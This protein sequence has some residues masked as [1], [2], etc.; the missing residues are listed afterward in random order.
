MANIALFGLDIGKQTFHVV[1]HDAQGRPVFKRQFTRSR[2]LEFFATQPAARIVMEAC[3]GA[4][5]LARKLASYGHTVQLIAPQYVRPFVTGNKNDFIDAQAICE[6]ASRPTMRYVAI[7][8]PEQQAMSALHR[9]R[10]ARI[11]ERTQAGN[12]IHS[13]LLEFGVAL[14]V[15][16]RGIKQVP[17]WLHDDSDLPVLARRVLERH[18]DHWCALNRQITE[19]DAEIAAQAKADD[20]ASRLMTVPGIGPIT[21]SQLAA[22]AGNAKGYGSA[23]D[24]AASLGLVPRQHSTGGK[25]KLLGISKRGDKSLRRLL[26]QCAHVIMQNAARWKSA[27]AEWTVAL[28]MRRHANIVACALANKLAR[29]VWAI[30]AKGGEYH[31]QPRTLS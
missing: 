1:G 4:H 18:F 21:A 27:M 20:V 9:L 2:L 31:P 22:D 5:W 30:L 26:V 11:S 23:R 3:C 25:A 17:A 24:F 19:L 12:Q 13:L 8:S 15:G 7:K 28:M 10:E 14:P 6:A 16:T 29:V